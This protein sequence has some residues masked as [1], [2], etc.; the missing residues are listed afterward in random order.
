MR[1]RNQLP[2]H[3]GEPE[4]PALRQFYPAVFDGGGIQVTIRKSST[5]SISTAS[6]G[7]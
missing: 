6:I 3:F 4:S 7:F 1:R 5:T 2:I